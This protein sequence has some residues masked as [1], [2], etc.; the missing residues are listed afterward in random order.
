V[1]FSFSKFEIFI[2]LFSGVSIEYH[3]EYDE[4]EHVGEQKSSNSSKS[5]LSLLLH[6]FSVFSLVFS[7]FFLF[8]KS[9]FFHSLFCFHAFISSFFLSISTNFI[10]VLSKNFVFLSILSG[11]IQKIDNNLAICKFLCCSSFNSEGSHL[12]FSR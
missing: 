7:C 5:S 11:I 2:F 4:Y 3:Q 10:I 12:K 8:K 9:S 1:N 6:F